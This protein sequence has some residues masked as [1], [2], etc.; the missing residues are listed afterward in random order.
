MLRNVRKST[1]EEIRA[2]FDNDVERFSNLETG[3]SAAV[4]SPL[5]LDLIAEA[6]ARST[7]Q[8]TALVDIGCG[9]GNLAL[10]VLEFAPRL[11]V[12]LI[13]LSQPMLTRAVERIGGGHAIQGDIRDVPLEPASFDIAVG[14]AVFH[15][16]RGVEEW[17]AVF[18]KIYRSLRPGGS[19]WIADLIFHST[20]VVQDIMWRRYGE[21]L[22]G[23]KGADYRQH[24]FEYIEAEDTPRPLLFQID[25]LRET[26]FR[27]VEILHK[28]SC[29]AAF[30]AL[31]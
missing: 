17:R 15:H 11:A 3:Q 4:D 18:A 19:F 28:N 13:D 30:G 27:E 6:A 5:M 26:G 12:T 23:L 7:P 16:L 25:L 10:K 29:F 2:R 22:T 1:T 9:A 24:V 8:A 14:A 31:K 21:Y 20:P